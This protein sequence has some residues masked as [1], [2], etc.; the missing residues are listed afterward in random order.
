[1]EN[2]KE[3]TLGDLAKG[4]ARY[5][6][7]ILAV[8]VI[9]IALVAF[10]GERPANSGSDG[11]DTALQVGRTGDD[12]TSDTI[13]GDPL[14]GV[15]GDAAVDAARAEQAIRNASGGPN[16][17]SLSPAAMGPD[18]DPTTNRVRM[19]SRAAVPCIA[20]FS[21]NNGGATYQGV[22]AKEIKVVYYQPTADP[23][24]TAALTAAGA[25]NT[26]PEQE[27]TLRDYIDIFNKHFPMYGRHVVIEVKHGSGDSEDDAAGRADAV[28]IAT[29]IK[30]F[31]VFGSPATNAFPAELAARKILC[32]CTT[33][34]PQEFYEQYSPYVGY[35]SLMASTQG[36]IHR[37]E[38]VANRLNGRNASHSGN[39]VMRTSKRVFGLLYYDTPDHGYRVG[40]QFFDKHLKEKYGI[41]LKVIQEYPSDYA[42]GAG[43]RS[44]LHPEDEER[45]PACYQHLVRL[46]SDRSGVAD[47]GSDEPAVLSRVDHHRLGADRHHLVR[48]HL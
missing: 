4:F 11:D 9:L 35:T 37:A 24:V 6:P 8:V 43:E 21:G 2:W 40:A 1:M 29:R 12:S 22:T 45:Q 15:T 32:I 48:A 25:A 19:P 26:E 44:L 33:S 30:P 47:Q 34:Q 14:E 5:R 18:C 27:S 16:V 10:P 38:Y 13:A 36:Y 46:R 39:A 23:A 3:M 28:D 31:A 20:P 42:A 41:T 7:F 17:T